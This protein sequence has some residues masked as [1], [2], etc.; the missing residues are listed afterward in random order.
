MAQNGD[1]LIAL[2]AAGQAA[3][4]LVAVT[5]TPAG[6]AMGRDA[7]GMPMPVEGGI[8]GNAQLKALLDQ[9]A[10]FLPEEY[11]RKWGLRTR[12]VDALNGMKISQR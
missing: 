11:R 10:D 12:V 4:G 1:V 5:I 6:L 9:I 3:S 7:S 8:A 2:P